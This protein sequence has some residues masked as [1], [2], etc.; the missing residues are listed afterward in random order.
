[1]KPKYKDLKFK[2]EKEFQKWL[3]KTTKIEIEFEDDGQDFL[4][5]W[6]DEN[7]EVLYSDLQSAVKYHGK[8]KT[9]RS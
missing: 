4:R 7:G 6:L 8:Y 1:M 2:S 5:W 3:N 9:F